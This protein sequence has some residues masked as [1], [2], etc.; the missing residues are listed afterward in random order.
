MQI[1]VHVKQQLDRAAWSGVLKYYYNFADNISLPGRK[2]GKRMK[3]L[4]QIVAA[5][6][7]HFGAIAWLGLHWILNQ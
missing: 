3:T 1:A 4:L 2:R 7:L 5:E 6:F